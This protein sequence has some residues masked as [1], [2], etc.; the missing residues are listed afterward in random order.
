MKVCVASPY[1]LSELKGNSVTTDRIVA[2]LNEGGVEA[3]GSYGNDGE[4]ADI[5]ITLHAI[6]GAPAVF[7]FKKK[8][9]NGRV[10]I[11]LTGTDIYQGLAEGSQ[12]GGDALQVAD[13]IVVP[14]EAALRKLPEK[15]RGKT[16]VIRPSLDPIAVKATSSQSPFVI[17]VVGHLRPVKR[18]FLTIET[19]AQHP[20][21]SD[22][23]VWQIGQALDAE[24]RK[25]AEFWMEEDKRYRWCGGLPREESLALCAK[26]SL[27]INSSILE[28]GANA[29]L[30]AMT[31][32]VPVLASRIEG[33][34]GLM[35]DDYPGYFEE[36]G[37]AKAL[38]AIMHQ[39][40]DLDEWSLLLADR[41][42]LFSRVRES[43][44]WLEL[45]IELK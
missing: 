32:G 24:M 2:M 38:E 34:V 43:E 21:W 40:V 23:E 31:M 36:G 20:E 33:N 19:L 5:L 39:R 41:L 45:L 25:T 17:S 11:L 8:T 18:P 12:I 26:S 9:P 3:R 10:I 7:D 4:P 44:S 42:P 29:V 35:G 16:V 15:V 30:E 37:M 13:R 27:T 1:P 14:Q 6:K 28:G 22:L